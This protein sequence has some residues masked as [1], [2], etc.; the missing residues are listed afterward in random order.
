MDRP[1]ELREGPG[2]RS[3]LR[4][5]PDDTRS[6]RTGG[7]MLEGGADDVEE[8]WRW[9]LE[10]AAHGDIVVLGATPDEG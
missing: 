4:G 5:T 8:A 6:H 7:A 2:F 9:F 10:R 3:W 1:P